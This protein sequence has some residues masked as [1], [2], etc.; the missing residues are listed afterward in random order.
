MQVNA[1]FSVMKK[2]QNQL[3]MTQFVLENYLIFVSLFFFF[4]I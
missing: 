1:K 4:L 2:F 3:D